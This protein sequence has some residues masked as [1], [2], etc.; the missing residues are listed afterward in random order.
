MVLFVGKQRVEIYVEEKDLEV[1]KA[2][3]MEFVMSQKTLIQQMK[4]PGSSN[5]WPKKKNRYPSHNEDNNYTPYLLAYA[6]TRA[7]YRE[8]RFLI[9]V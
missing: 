3:P 9:N 1:D 7:V 5:F 4:H 6:Y 8:R 2:T